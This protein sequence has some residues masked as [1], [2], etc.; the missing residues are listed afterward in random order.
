MTALELRILLLQYLCISVRTKLAWRRSKSL[1]GIAI[2][3]GIL[4]TYSKTL[5]LFG[6]L[7]QLELVLLKFAKNIEQMP[8]SRFSAH[9]LLNRLP[10]M[11]LASHKRCA[12]S[13]DFLLSSAVYIIFQPFYLHKLGGICFNIVKKRFIR[14]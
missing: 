7:H 12:L 9:K 2:E 13:V 6:S 8:S 10:S 5:L 1:Y 11:S 3:R 14:H 4:V